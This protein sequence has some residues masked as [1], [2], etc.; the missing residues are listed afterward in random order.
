[1][2]RISVLERKLDFDPSLTYSCETG[3]G[4]GPCPK[5]KGGESRCE[6]RQSLKG[7]VAARRVDGGGS[8]KSAERPLLLVIATGLQPYRE[9]LFASISR[10]YR[11]YLLNNAETTWERPYVA[12][13]D[14]IPD[15]STSAVMAAALRAHEKERLCGVISW[16]ESRILVASQVAAELG[17]RG[18]DVDVIERC[19]DKFLSRTAWQNAGVPQPRFAL[20]G[21]VDEARA[22]AES[23]G[24][25][26]VLKPRAAGASYGVVLVNDTRQLRAHFDFA[27]TGR[28]VPDDPRH[29]QPVLVEEFVPGPEASVDSVVADGRITP[30]FLARKEV[31]FE[32]YF[33]ETGHSLRYP[34]PMLAVEP[35]RGVL[36]AAHAALGF[37]D[38]WTHV[39]LKLTAA[40]PRVIELNGRLGGDLIPYLGQCA[41]GIEPGLLAAAAACGDPIEVSADRGLAAAIR[42]F[43]VQHVD[44]VIDSVA[45]DRSTLPPEIDRAEP[46]VASGSIVSPPPRGLLTGRIAL[47]TAVAGSVDQ[48]R[49]ALDQAGKALRVRLRR[50]EVPAL[51]QPVDGVARP[52]R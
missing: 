42:F 30:L 19:R 39:E 41:S 9:Y 16:D 31:G 5:G 7:Y 23:I 40:G 21:S 14:L 48:C 11:I 25:P 13:A 8:T 6:E 52:A 10:R 45:F 35:L 37:R 2:T 4:R 46:L 34:Q 44:S 27:Y 51:S 22:S 18:G 36:E 12:A 24:Y 33:E 26:V 3:E 20:V 17:L 43:Y 29:P 47:A 32:P 49:T 1:M 15:F 50:P 38:G 28:L